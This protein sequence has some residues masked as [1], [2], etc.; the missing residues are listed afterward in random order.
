VSRFLKYVYPLDD[1]HRLVLGDFNPG[2]QPRGT[3]ISAELVRGGNVDITVIWRDASGR[4]V[5][6][7]WSQSSGWD[8][9]NPPNDGNR[10]LDAPTRSVDRT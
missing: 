9:P 1:A 3:P 6:S 7:S 8:L 2:V 4:V 10:L 5:S